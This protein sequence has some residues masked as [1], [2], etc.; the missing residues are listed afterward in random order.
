MHGG[1]KY[2]ANPRRLLVFALDGKAKLPPQ[3]GRTLA[4]EP[5]DDPALA[6]DEA[7]ASAGQSMFLGCALC[8]G[9][10]AISSGAPAPDLRESNL[11]LDPAAFRQV[12]KEGAKIER[13]MPR[14]DTL[15]DE[16]VNQLWHY[17]RREA[18]KAAAKKQGG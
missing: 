3:P 17:V 5:V 15:S 8:H 14:F 6:I 7:A 18:R 2:G 13:G 11:A 16:Q 12:V 9:R 1:W 4:L 10:D